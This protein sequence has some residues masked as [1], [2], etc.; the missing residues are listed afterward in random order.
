MPITLR[1]EEKEFQQVPPG[2]Y[3][4]RCYRLVECGVQPDSG[5]GEKAKLVI[6]WEL[7]NERVTAPDGTDKPMSISQFYNPSL[8][9]KAKLRHDLQ[10]WRGKD[11]TKEEVA[12]FKLA[13]ILGK[14]CQV[15]VIKNEKGRSIVGGIM[16][17]PKGMEVPPLENKAVEYA[18]EDGKNEVYK[19]LP[20]WL[21]SMVDA[22]LKHL[23]EQAAAQPADPGPEPDEAPPYDPDV[24]F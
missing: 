8:N 24:G 12:E 7:P 2:T 15:S 13:A 3:L 23:A 20:D 11:F 14:P 21:R 18:L 4:A 19:N 22:G 10:N 16:G 1:E 9:V 17:C 6:T 5:Y